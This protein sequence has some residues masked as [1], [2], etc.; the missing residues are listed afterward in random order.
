M[1]SWRLLVGVDLGLGLVCDSG[2]MVAGSG[3]GG[4]VWW[5]PGRAGFAC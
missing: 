2:L 4:V 1:V 3:F 5:F